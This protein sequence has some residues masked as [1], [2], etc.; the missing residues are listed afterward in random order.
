MERIDELAHNKNIEGIFDIDDATKVCLQ[1]DRIVGIGKELAA[2]DAIDCGIF[3]CSP[4]VFRAIDHVLE[5]ESDCSLSQAM[6][7]LGSKERFF[8][9]EIGGRW[10]QDVDTPEM[11]AQAERL[12]GLDR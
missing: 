11:L 12:L 9:F 6:D 2:Y 7:I 5:T 1:G 3:R 4:A 10:W 8:G